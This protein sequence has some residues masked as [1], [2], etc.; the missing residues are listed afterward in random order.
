MEAGKGRRCCLLTLPRVSQTTFS[1]VTIIFVGRMKNLGVF[2]LRR[3]RARQ[4]DVCDL[5]EIDDVF[6]LLVL[7]VFVIFCSFYFFYF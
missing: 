1:P 7:R 3:D 5:C 6:V 4:M 2:V